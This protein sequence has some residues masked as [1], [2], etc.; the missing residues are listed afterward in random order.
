VAL[1]SVQPIPPP[2]LSLSLSLFLFFSEALFKTLPKIRDATFVK[3]ARSGG[4]VCLLSLDEL[5]WEEAVPW[6]RTNKDG[7]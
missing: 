6:R 7:T 5:E 1:L 4:N 2:L 3:E